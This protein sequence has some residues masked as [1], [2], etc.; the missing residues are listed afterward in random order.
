[1]DFPHLQFL[2]NGQSIEVRQLEIDQETSQYCR[3]DRVQELAPRGEGP[4][5]QAGTREPAAVRGDDA[6]LEAANP[7]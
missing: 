5:L 1:M 2:D 7:F 6:P 4:G 3:R